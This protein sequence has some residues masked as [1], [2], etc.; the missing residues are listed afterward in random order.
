MKV[1]GQLG[2]RSGAIDGLRAKTRRQDAH[3]KLRLGNIVENGKAFRGSSFNC[4]CCSAFGQ[5]FHLRA[6]NGGGLWINYLDSKI[7]GKGR[8]F[9]KSERQES[10]AQVSMT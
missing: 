6:E 2:L 7:C 5:Q 3:M 9:Q 4:K 8:R 1:Y 10:E